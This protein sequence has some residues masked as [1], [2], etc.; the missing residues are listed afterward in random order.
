[1]ALLLFAVRIVISAAY[2][3]ASSALVDANKTQVP[4]V[5]TSSTYPD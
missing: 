4:D 5:S 2:S 3:E 1:M